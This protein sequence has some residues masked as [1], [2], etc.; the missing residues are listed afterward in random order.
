MATGMLEE[1]R[2]ACAEVAA[3]ARQVRIV[4]SV[5]HRYAATLDPQRLALPQMDPACHYLGTARRPS[6]FCSPSMPSISVPASFPPSSPVR[7][8][9]ASSPSPP[10][11]SLQLDNL[12]WHR[13]QTL[14]F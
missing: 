2:A 1:V 14:F 5:I 11:N 9:R 13:T 10:V 4:E 3:A 7:S 6:S 12:L 8:N